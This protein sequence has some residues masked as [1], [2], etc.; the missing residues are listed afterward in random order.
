MTLIF[1]KKP[2]LL[3]DEQ[4]EIKSFGIKKEETI[5]SVGVLTVVLAIVSF[6]LFCVIDMVFK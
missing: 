3:F 5:Y 4:G 2:T 6:Y 1:L